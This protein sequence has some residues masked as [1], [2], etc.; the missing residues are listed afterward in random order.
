M[1]KKEM[2]DDAVILR[3]RS[4]PYSGKDAET[5]GQGVEVTAAIDYDATGSKQSGSDV[6]EEIKELSREL[7]EIKRRFFFRM[8]LMCLP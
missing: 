5:A 7:K 8:Q 1:V 3:T 4:V 6:N 2:G